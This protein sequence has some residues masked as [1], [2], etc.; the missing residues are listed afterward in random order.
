[1]PWTITVDISTANALLEKL[2]SAA[3]STI[4]QAAMQAGAEK[5]V[6]SARA[7]APVRTGALRDS[8]DVAQVSAQGASVVAEVE[9]SGFVEF[10]TSRMSAEPY[11]RPGIPTASAAAVEAAVSALEEAARA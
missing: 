11:M 7:A 6:E 3:T 4:P 5:L 2:A 9:Y 10:G 1:M 8:I